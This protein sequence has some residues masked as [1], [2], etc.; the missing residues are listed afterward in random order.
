[1]KGRAAG[2]QFW[3]GTPKYHPSQIW[4]SNFREEDL[5]VKVYDV[6]GPPRDGKAHMVFGQVS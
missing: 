5:N 6:W 4:F 3:K 2:H 1:M